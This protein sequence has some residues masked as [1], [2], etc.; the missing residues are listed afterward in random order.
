MTL[1]DVHL[2]LSLGNKT[3]WQAR[4]GALKVELETF[5]AGTVVQEQKHEILLSSGKD[6]QSTPTKFN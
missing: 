5:F 3:Y 1:K 6:S 4:Q 2:N